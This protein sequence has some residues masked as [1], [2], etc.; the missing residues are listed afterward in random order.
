MNNKR[1]PLHTGNGCSFI[2]L[3]VS[4][5]FRC[6]SVYIY[7]IEGESSNHIE[8]KTIQEDDAFILSMIDYLC[9]LPFM[10]YLCDKLFLFDNCCLIHFLFCSIMPFPKTLTFH[11]ERVLTLATKN[12]RKITVVDLSLASRWTIIFILM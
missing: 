2:L 10:I 4:F 7:L 1:L 6:M 8:Q 3:L 12:V 11:R 9:L 5:F